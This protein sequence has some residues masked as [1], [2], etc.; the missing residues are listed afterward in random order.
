[1]AIVEYNYSY[2]VLVSSDKDYVAVTT[3]PTAIVFNNG[4]D[5]YWLSGE[6]DIPDNAT[7]AD[8]TG[9]ITKLG[10]SNI[11][12]LDVP[13]SNRFVEF[14]DISINYSDFLSGS[15]LDFSVALTGDDEIAGSDG[16]DAIVGLFGAGDGNDV[17]RLGGGNDIAEAGAGNDS[18]QGGEGND[19]LNGEDG[20]DTAY[21]GGTRDMYDLSFGARPTIT[22]TMTNEGTDTLISVERLQFSDGTLAFDTD[23]A[24]GQAYRLYQAAFDRT[25]DIEGLTF[26][27]KTFDTGGLTLSEMAQSFIDSAEF[28]NLYGA[29]GTVSDVEFITLLYNNVLDRD[30]DAEGFDYWLGQ[31]DAGISRADTLR[32]FSE[33]AENIA[34]VQEQIA[35]GIWY[36]L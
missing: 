11:Y 26:W 3:G 18:L 19:L 5:F 31:A 27:T 1:M 6:F 8:V 15:G 33:S 28:A 23:G 21:Y 29:Q 22:S 32:Y 10:W 13:L 30:P 12:R 16:A 35:D 9:T 25:P 24:A 7:L 2:E 20:L 4:R 14:T 34:N 36:G 17:L